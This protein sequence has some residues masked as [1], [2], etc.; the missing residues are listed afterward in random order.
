MSYPSTIIEASAQ[1]TAAEKSRIEK[2]LYDVF[3]K[4]FS[5]TQE[6]LRQSCGGEGSGDLTGKSA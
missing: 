6:A 2:A 1:T 3:A 5:K 4:Y